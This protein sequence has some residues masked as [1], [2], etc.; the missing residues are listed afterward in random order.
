[1]NHPW[2]GKSPTSSARPKRSRWAAGRFQWLV[3]IAVAC[4][5][6]SAGGLLSETVGEDFSARARA[7]RPGEG[8]SASG[9]FVLDQ[10][11]SSAASSSQGDA[12][13]LNRV[14]SM[15]PEEQPAES[16]CLCS[17]SLFQDGFESGDISSWN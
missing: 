8:R 12:F 1:M 4:L 15:D 14:S 5:L 3:S 6:F 13:V 7:L 9:S 17:A 2:H 10:R 16:D 11:R